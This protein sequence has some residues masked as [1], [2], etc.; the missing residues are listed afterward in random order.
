[1]EADRRQFTAALALLRAALAEAQRPE[2]A[3]RIADRIAI[4]EK[5]AAQRSE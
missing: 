1:M 3:A 5:L 4:V 2:L